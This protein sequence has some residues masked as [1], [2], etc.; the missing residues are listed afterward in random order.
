MVR[1]P[2]RNGDAPRTTEAI[3]L[4]NQ[5]GHW[6]LKEI[7]MAP[8]IQHAHS[9]H[10]AEC[11][12]RATIPDSLGEW[13]DEC[14]KRIGIIRKDFHAF[15]R[16]ADNRYHS[17]KD[18]IDQWRTQVVSGERE[19]DHDEET[20]YKQALSA[21]ISFAS[22]LDEKYEAYRQCGILLCNTRV[23]GLLLGRKQEFEK[24]LRDWHSPEW[25][26]TN[27]RTVKWD[28]EQTRHL[29]ARLV[30]CE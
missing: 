4:S 13:D 1:C 28:K 19:F 2:Q 18:G 10:A 14:A 8:T 21:L 30:S 26:V 11:H 5:Q 12:A 27:E 16:L 24:V 7:D 29:R 17:L 15:I 23:M 3:P 20:E 6:P 9:I 22:L 25:E